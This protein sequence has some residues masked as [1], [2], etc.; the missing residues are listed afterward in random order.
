[1][2]AMILCALLCAAGPSPEKVE[3]AKMLYKAASKAYELS[4]YPVA[5]SAFEASYQLAPRSQ[6]VFSLAQAY[7]MHAMT[8][9]D[10]WKLQRA[11]TLYEE[12]LER[13]P[14]GKRQRHAKQH[15]N[16]LGPVLEQMKLTQPQSLERRVAR[17][18]QFM[19]SSSIVDA[20][21]TIGSEVLTEFPD[22][23]EVKPGTYT[24][25]FD[26]PGY[27]P[28]SSQLKIP[29]GVTLPLEVDLVPLPAQL[30]ISAPDGAEIVVDGISRGEAPLSQALEV[31]AGT[32]FVAILKTGSYA[33]A[34]EVSTGR[35]AQS[36]V[37]AK[38]ESTTQRTVSYAF[39]GTGA[40]LFVGSTL[41]LLASGANQKEALRLESELAEHGLTEQQARAHA[42][43]AA[44]RDR[45]RNLGLGL[46]TAAALTGTAAILLFAL[47]TPRA[48]STVSKPSLA[49]SPLLSPKFAGAGVSAR[50]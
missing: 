31:P 12:Y 2:K 24:V 19:I 20:Q 49:F 1:M 3:Q 44:T 50:F 13:F 10:P 22:T 35:G 23:L 40:I 9:N 8:D 17:A 42:N 41:A 36:S 29:V 39:M 43:Q 11:L 4:N 6:V 16:L 45:N 25:K 7:R 18:T 5:I 47:D 34:E 48:P 21:V 14:A 28:K 32:H 37:V 27:Q 46:G 26:A 38:L 30:R 33:Y 15:K